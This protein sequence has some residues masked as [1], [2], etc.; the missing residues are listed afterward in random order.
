VSESTG[1]FYQTT[2]DPAD[3]DRI[4]LGIPWDGTVSGRPGARF[5]PAAIRAATLNEEDY[6]P[7]LN[8]DIG[9]FCLADSGDIEFPFGDTVRALSVIEDTVRG[10]AAHNVP[11]I[12]LGGEHLVTL[13]VVRALHERYGDSLCVVQFDA[14]AD[15]RGEYLGVDLS[16]ATVM[17]HIADILDGGN[18]AH[19]GI[20]SGTAGE[21]AL[22]RT[23]PRYFGG[24]QGKSLGAFGKFA[25][26]ELSGRKVYITVDL[27]VFDPAVC[28]GTGTPEPG[29]LTFRDFVPLINA[30]A[31]CDIVG[32]DI[33]ELA[34]DY[35]GSGISAALAAV[36]LREL[37]LI[38]GDVT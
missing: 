37:L 1:I 3:A 34:P 13:P 25:R 17:H 7:Y 16:H 12:S 10:L 9:D 27:D 31:G 22:L 35:D 4:I 28:P 15:L 20:R 38:A 2:V 23:H 5:G 21:F 8:R 6:S 18:T 26:S 30:L 36:V 14:H 19:V 29:G 24:A 32:A 33:V 11:I